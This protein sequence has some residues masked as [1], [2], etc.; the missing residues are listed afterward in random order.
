M[1]GEGP[2]LAW[3]TDGHDLS[4]PC[5]KRADHTALADTA[6]RRLS[7]NSQTTSGWKKIQKL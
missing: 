5:V 4:D 2:S 6:Y 7:E 3:E 1:M